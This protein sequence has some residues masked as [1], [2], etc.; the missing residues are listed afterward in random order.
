VVFIPKIIHNSPLLFNIKPPA[1]YVKEIKIAPMT[2]LK[3]QNL[4]IFQYLTAGE[5]RN[6]TQVINNRPLKRRILKI[7]K[8]CR[9]KP[10]KNP[11]P[12][13]TGAGK[14]RYLISFFPSSP[15]YLSF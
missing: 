8:T 6:Y 5:F 10:K 2:A 7:S 14:R 13:F 11:A 15:F 4:F 12:I 1:I 3:H 9:L